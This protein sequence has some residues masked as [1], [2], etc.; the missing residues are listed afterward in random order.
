MKTFLILLGLSI[1]LLNTLRLIDFVFA[2]P[3]RK[4]EKETRYRIR[5]QY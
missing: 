1:G 5:K 3:K 4:N 2:L